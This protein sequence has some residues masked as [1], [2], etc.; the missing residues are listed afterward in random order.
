VASSAL[1]PASSLKEGQAAHQLQQR[2]IRVC[3]IQPGDLIFTPTLCCFAII[4][5]PFG[6]GK[7][8]AAQAPSRSPG[9]CKKLKIDCPSYFI[10]PYS[11][12]L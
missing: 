7:R 10:L 4:Q 9:Y 11:L 2:P 8:M 12:D 1:L 5:G 6:R 3:I